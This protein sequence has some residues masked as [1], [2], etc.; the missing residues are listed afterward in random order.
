MQPFKLYPWLM[1]LFSVWVLVSVP[2]YALVGL[3][4]QEAF[5]AGGVAGFIVVII[6]AILT[7]KGD[8]DKMMIDELDAGGKLN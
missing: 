3:G 1:L 7:G 5:L 4:G 6:M 2:Y 8:F